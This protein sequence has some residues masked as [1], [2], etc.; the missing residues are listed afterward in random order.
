MNWFS[1]KMFSLFI[2]CAQRNDGNDYALHNL[3]AKISVFFP[4]NAPAINNVYYRKHLMKYHNNVLLWIIKCQGDYYTFLQI[5]KNAAIIS[6]TTKSAVN[7]MCGETL[8]TW[9]VF[10]LAA[11]RA[12]IDNN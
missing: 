1:I 11:F 4:Q 12:I 9:Y 7:N 3:C 2:K 8:T 10:L 5:V 6:S